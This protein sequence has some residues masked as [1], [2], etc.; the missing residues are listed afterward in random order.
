MTESEVVPDG[1]E[2]VLLDVSG[3]RPVVLAG[4][5]EVGPEPAWVDELHPLLGAAAAGG[6]AYL[7]TAGGQATALDGRASDSGVRVLLGPPT[8]LTPQLA[9]WLGARSSG[10]GEAPGT[11][12]PRMSAAE[13]QP[14]DQ[15]RSLLRSRALAQDELLARVLAWLLQGPAR[16]VAVVGCPPDARID[17]LWG[18]LEIAAPV[19]TARSWTF[20]TADTDPA[21]V[22]DEGLPEIVFLSARPAGTPRVRVI[23]DLAARQGASPANEYQA[24]S[25]VFR[26]EF[27]RDPVP[28]QPPPVQPPPAQ[29]APAPAA[30][31]QRR[32]PAR[33]PAAVDHAVIADEVARL[34]DARGE[35]E[36]ATALR[37]LQ[38]EV[39][40][41]D[42]RA[43]LRAQLDRVDWATEAIERSLGPDHRDPARDWLVRIALGDR[44]PDVDD[45]ER[46]VLRSGS[47]PLARSVGRVAEE[48]GRLD[49]VAPALAR[50]WLFDPA[51][52][53]PEPPPLSG[54]ARVL[55]L[56]GVTMPP[57]LERR[58][59][60]G[61]L[62]ALALVL[63]LLIGLVL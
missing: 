21:A 18:L 13:Q 24:N 10:D 26:Y 42:E 36:L 62:I 4:S 50:R 57:E 33:R 14:D 11:P 59:A 29:Y 37:A 27:G 3:S 60:T 25:L 28:V 51:A 31:P 1:I 58:I 44:M 46:V 22:D 47:V 6:L 8:A 17:L 5:F 49:P 2:Q 40:E 48:F 54:P 23:V 61:L 15:A 53:A 7:H 16:P 9:L 39:V 56:V 20:T 63:G 45:A 12:L 41:P 19:L 34:A 43:V 35:F 32:P 55:E 38:Q 30:P 52:V